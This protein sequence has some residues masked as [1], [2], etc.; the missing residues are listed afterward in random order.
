MVFVKR[1]GWIMD[2]GVEEADTLLCETRND[3]I[4]DRCDI[5]DCSLKHTS[6]A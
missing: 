1:I 4:R 5:E 3:T 6:L 2:Y